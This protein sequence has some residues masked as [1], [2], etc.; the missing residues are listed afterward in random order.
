MNKWILQNSIRFLSRNHSIL[1]HT[2]KITNTINFFCVQA[3]PFIWDSELHCIV[4]ALVHVDFC[5]YINLY[6]FF[7]IF[8]CAHMGQTQKVHFFFWFQHLGSALTLR[9]PENTWKADVKRS[10]HLVTIGCEVCGQV[11]GWLCCCYVLR[12]TTMGYLLNTCARY[13]P[14]RYG[15]IYYYFFLFHFF[16]IHEP[17][18]EVVQTQHAK[19]QIVNGKLH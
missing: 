16:G 4:A 1:L 9:I 2:S 5:I 6:I 18:V 19:L 13:C 17:T 12:P 11:P 8:G 7:S 10:N 14:N 3:W 15:E